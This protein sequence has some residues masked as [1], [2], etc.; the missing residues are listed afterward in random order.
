MTNRGSFLRKQSKIVIKLYR[1]ICL[2][3]VENCQ[4]F[5]KKQKDRNNRLEKE[6]RSWTFTAK[7]KHNFQF[8]LV[9]RRKTGKGV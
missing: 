2:L 6:I 9:N 8:L 3:L 7:N 4:V 5:I 1:I